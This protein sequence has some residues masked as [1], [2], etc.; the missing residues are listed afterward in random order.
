MK[1]DTRT[2]LQ[3]PCQI[4]ARRNLIKVLI[5]S[6]CIWCYCQ[7]CKLRGCINHSPGPRELHDAEGDLRLGSGSY[8]VLGGDRESRSET[9]SETRGEQIRSEQTNCCCPRP[10]QSPSPATC[11]PVSSHRVSS[12]GP[13]HTVSTVS[14]SWCMLPNTPG[15]EQS[16]RRQKFQTLIKQVLITSVSSS[17]HSY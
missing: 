16:E 4:Q 9:R 10:R 5:Y 8:L 6:P 7:L 3:I 12:L 17:D 11:S 1:S 15:D 14:I 13:V 2:I